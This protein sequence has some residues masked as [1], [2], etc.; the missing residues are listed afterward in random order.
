MKDRVFT[1]YDSKVGIY[2]DPF[3]ALNEGQAERAMANLVSNPE[4]HFSRYSQDFTLFEIGEYDK[5]LGVYT[6]NQAHRRISGLWEI[7]QRLSDSNIPNLGI[8][9]DVVQPIREAKGH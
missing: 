4:H 6:M 5:S 1:V 8:T 2:M 7:K 9:P 3:V